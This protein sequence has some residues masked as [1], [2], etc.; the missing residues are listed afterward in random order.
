MS[1]TNEIIGSQR[2]VRSLQ[3]R[4]DQAHELIKRLSD[5]RTLLAKLAASGPA[6]H[7]PLEAMA[8][9][10]VRDSVLQMRHGRSRRTKVVLFRRLPEAIR[11]SLPVGRKN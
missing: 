11:L 10:S 3:K 1:S 9:Q 5:E 8:A 6:F 4:L 2:K 7:N